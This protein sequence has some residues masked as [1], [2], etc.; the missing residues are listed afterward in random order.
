MKNFKKGLLML[1]MLA[2]G[3]ALQAQQTNGKAAHQIVFQLSSSD[4]LA[5][6]GL[7]NN[8]RHLK[9]GWG[10]KVTIEVV[11]HGPGIELLMAAKTT[12]REAIGRHKAAG[13]QFFACE[14]TLKEK[15][16]PKEAIIGEAGFVPMG[17]GH[18]VERQEQGWSYIKSGF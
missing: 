8:L 1:A 3:A 14:N 11:A 4:T 16:I 18:I 6:K 5:W 9:E 17:I 13:I 15:K 10:D 7:M 12:Q 2:F